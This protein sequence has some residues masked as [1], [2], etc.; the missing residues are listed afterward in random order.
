LIPSDNF[1]P[2][3]MT[4]N[5][6]R[7]LEALK[8]LGVIGTDQGD[9]FDIYSEL[10]LEVSGFFAATC[11]LIDVDTQHGISLCSLNGE[12]EKM[13][14][15]KPVKVERAQ[16]PCAYTILTPE[17]LLVPD[18]REHKIFKD[19]GTVKAGM[20]VAYA[21]F[22]IINKDNY[23]FGTICL[24]DPNIKK[25]KKQEIKLLEKLTKRL[26]HQLDTQAEQKAVTAEKISLAIGIFEE[27]VSECSL[28]DF[29]Y[30]I[31][32][33]AGRDI[34]LEKC[35]NLKS[36]EL[37]SVNKNGSMELTEK[38][39]ELQIKMGLQTRTLNKRKVEGEAANLLVDSMLSELEAL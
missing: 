24:F 30:F 16:S 38:G 33:C 39:Q 2:A 11:S 23:V 1:K 8:R 35:H 37:C 27:R 29:K 10:A 26:A 15:G 22:P 9:I 7:R 32:L 28:K 3:P 18:C 14:E 6:E 19:A 34:E 25:L 5:E 21:G 36:N 4:S 12:L 13:T 31:N 20:V 17:P